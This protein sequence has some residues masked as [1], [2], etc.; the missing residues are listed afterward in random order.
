MKMESGKKYTVMELAELVGVPRTTIND[1]LTKYAI[2]IQSVPQGR[3]RVYTESAL[4][5][6]K[7]IAALRSNGLPLTEIETQLA[8]TCAIQP[9]PETPQPPE[10]KKEISSTGTMV[11]AA[12]ADAALMKQNAGELLVRFREMMEKI[13]RLEAASHATPGGEFSVRNRL[14]LLTLLLLTA[15]FCGGA[16]FAKTEFDAMHRKAVLRE[17]ELKLR[18]DENRS[19]Q[20]KIGILD[21][22]KKVF[23]QD[24]SRMKKEIE[25]GKAARREDAGKAAQQISDL[26][27]G[28]E[29]IIRSER[30]Q[31]DAEAALQKERFE[32]N[33]LELIR[34]LEKKILES[35]KIAAEKKLLEHQKAELEKTCA[36][37]ADALRKQTS[38]PV[39]KKT[40]PILKTVPAHSEKPAP[41]AAPFP[42]AP[43]KK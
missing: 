18:A 15:I 19:L 26:K 22:N 16:Y 20:K 31:R 6:L 10:N 3:R 36:A 40:R 4:N 24:L 12:P 7:K 2:Y 39:P 37:Q 43:E 17:K 35:E 28:L 13:D 9:Q 1:W 23:E 25:Q 41:T 14:F 27:A 34:Q 32:K 29:K 11:K 30:K 42:S 8:A 5:V 33:R 38:T 21:E